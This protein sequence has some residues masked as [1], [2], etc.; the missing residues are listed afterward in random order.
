MAWLV[1]DPRKG[2][3][4]MIVLPRVQPWMRKALD[5]WQL[6]LRQAARLD[7]PNLAPCRKRRAGRLAL[8]GPRA[9]RLPTLAERITTT[10]HAGSEV[11]TLG[12][13]TLQGLAFAHEAGPGPPRPAALSAAGSLT[14]ER[15][16]LA[17][18]AVASAMPGSRRPC[19]RPRR[20]ATRVPSAP[21]PN[22]RA[23]RGRADARL[24]GGPA[25]AGRSR[26]RPRRAPRAAHGR[27][28][29]R[30]PWT[31]RNRWPSRCAPSSTAPPTAR[32]ASATAMHAPCCARWKAGCRPMPMPAGGPLALLTDRLHSA[33]VLPALPGG[34]SRAARLA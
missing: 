15:C 24:A 14:G 3:D 10:G 34:A 5:D 23:G 31:R 2:Q 30:L 22:R 27:E 16:P 20:A 17:G 32:N 13:Q 4:L 21:R 9:R 7:H 12:V 8:G 19:H 11:A 26:R 29:V 28:F 33:G 18:L 6:A 1:H 25:R